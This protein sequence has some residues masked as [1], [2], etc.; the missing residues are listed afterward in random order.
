MHIFT[1]FVWLINSFSL[2][3]TLCWFFFFSSSFK[4]SAKN[5]K[6]ISELFYY[7]QK[8]VLHPTAPLY[9][10]ED[11]QVSQGRPFS[12]H[13]HL[14]RSTHLHVYTNDLC[15]NDIVVGIFSCSWNPCVSKPSAE[16]FT[17][18]TRTMT[19]SSVMLSSTAFRCWFKST[20][21]LLSSYLK[22]YHVVCRGRKKK[23]IHVSVQK[24]CFGNPLAP[25]AL[26]DVK[27]V[28]WKNT[29]DG[30]QD[31]G[32]TLNGKKNKKTVINR[33]YNVHVAA[34]LHLT[35]VLLPCVSFIR[36]LVPQYVIY[37]KRPTWNHM[38][39]PQEVWLWRQP[40]ADWWLSLPWV[41]V[42]ALLASWPL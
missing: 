28:V 25:Q 15:N 8:A 24:S 27:T 17:Y 10:P 13:R 14:F 2:K 23:T 16:Y 18:L 30:V 40:W 9:D 22:L 33:T 41:C 36:F 42:V 35:Y 26:E 39:D 29:S 37:P 4:C 5:L 38:D 1:P 20:S 34:V 11:K 6:N 7:A 21:R 12:Q 32:L 3:Q 31:N 19:V